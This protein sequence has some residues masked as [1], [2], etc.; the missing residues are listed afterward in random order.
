VVSPWSVDANRRDGAAPRGGTP[1]PWT[2][3]AATNQSRWSRVVLDADLGGEAGGGGM[4]GIG[5]GSERLGHQV[6]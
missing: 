4:H 6:E 1:G 5:R 3:P 2:P